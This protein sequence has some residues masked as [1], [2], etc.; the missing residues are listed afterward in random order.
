VFLAS[1]VTEKHL[2]KAFQ[3]ALLIAY[4]APMTLF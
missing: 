3:H 1:T 2:G 4:I